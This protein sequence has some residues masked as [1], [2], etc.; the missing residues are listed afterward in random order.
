MDEAQPV[1]KGNWV[2]GLKPDGTPL[3]PPSAPVGVEGFDKWFDEYTKNNYTDEMLAEA[4]WRA[5]LAQQ[6][7]P[8]G[9]FTAADMMDARQEGRKE[10]E[11]RAERLAE[12]L[13][14]LA[15]LDLRPDGF[16]KRP[17]DQTIYA[18]DRTAITVGDVRRAQAARRDHDQEEPG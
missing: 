5:A 17:D 2:R 15:G 7:A 1:A 11:A 3:P 6:P 9:G 4:A 12:A 8:D 16:D 10:A 13:R 14:P 18:R